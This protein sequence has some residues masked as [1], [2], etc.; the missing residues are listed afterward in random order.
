MT[1]SDQQRADARFQ[2]ALE[3]TGARDPR[4][5]Y[6][7]RLRALKA[8]NPEG[9]A[10][11]VGHYES[12]LIPS[13]ARGDADPLEA[14]LAYGLRIAKLTAEGRAVQIDGTGRAHPYEP[15]LAPDQ[16]LLHLPDG[17]GGRAFLVGLPVDPTPAQLATFDL[18]VNGKQK[19]RETTEAS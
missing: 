2:E 12:E 11:A 13:I 5:Y 19:M 14:W 1:E 18:L 7:E 10:Q 4:D 6:R 9:Y 8:D 3:G 16:M 15:P 17:R